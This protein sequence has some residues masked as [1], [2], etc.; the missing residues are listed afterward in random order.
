MSDNSDSADETLFVVFL[1]SFGHG[2]WE[3]TPWMRKNLKKG[4]MDAG[5]V[6]VTPVA[7]GSI[8][9]GLQPTDHGLPSVSRYETTPRQRP[10]AK[11]L[12]EIAVE[13]EHF[14][15][16]LNLGLPFIVPPDVEEGDSTYLHKSGGMGGNAVHYPQ[17]AAAQ[18]NVTGPVGDISKPDEE[19]DT[20]FEMRRD[21]TYQTFG[22][23]RQMAYQHDADVVFISFRTLDSYCHY[24][25]TRTPDNEAFDDTY[26]ELLLKEVDKEVKYL[27]EQ[28]GAEV[29]V[30]GDHGAMEMDNLFRVNRWLM[31][32]GYLEAEVDTGMTTVAR[33]KAEWLAE[34]GFI[35]EDDVSPIVGEDPDVPGS[36]ARHGDPNVEV[37]VENSVA[38]SADPFSGGITLLDADEEDEKRLVDELEQEEGV[39]RVFRTRDAWPGGV[40]EHECPD[41]YIERSP[42]TFVSGNFHPETGG[43]E[44]TRDGVHHPIGNY[45]A[46]VDI[47]TPQEPISPTDLFG[48]IAKDFLGLEPT[49]E[50][51][52]GSDGTVGGTERDVKQHLQDMGYL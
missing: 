12:P 47:G 43:P 15:S 28:E 18:L 29:M 24:N 1:D 34:S 10:A 32:N 45:G 25:Y 16:V 35:D 33:E 6:Y 49:V 5:P 14:D 46:T 11:T 20:A 23:A 48:V 39:E 38:I 7:M 3:H 42:G 19:L 51:T 37:D 36:V 22:N 44:R 21:H 2:D 52:G 30:F 17:E 8:Y 50:A 41:L 9:T 27:Y 26:R 31:E 4:Q 40:L 13:S